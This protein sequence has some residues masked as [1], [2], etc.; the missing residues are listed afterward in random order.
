[1]HIKEKNKKE[2]VKKKYN[3]QRETLAM[4]RITID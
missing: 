4:K 2:A 3:I 1:M